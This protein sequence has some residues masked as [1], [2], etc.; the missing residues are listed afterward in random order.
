MQFNPTNEFENIETRHP[1]PQGERNFA[2]ISKFHVLFLRA[3][4]GRPDARKTKTSNLTIMKNALFYALIAG[5]LAGGC[6]SAGTSTGKMAVDSATCERNSLRTE[7]VMAES[8]LHKT[9]L[10]FD[11]LVIDIRFDSAQRIATKR[12]AIRNLKAGKEKSSTKSVNEVK[13]DS[14]AM[15]TE[16]RAES[17]FTEERQ[18]ER[19][20]SPWKIFSLLMLILSGA[21]VYRTLRG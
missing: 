7:Y 18:I 16:K 21:L 3:R 6:K 19:N 11:S 12:Y 17:G 4:D 10:A 1:L 13:S 5:C 9:N 2:V 20:P 14:S 15:E 8:L